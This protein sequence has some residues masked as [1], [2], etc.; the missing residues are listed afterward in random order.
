MMN[1][2]GCGGG[3]PTAAAAANATQRQKTLQQRVDNDIGNIVE[4][5]S[6]IVN[7]SRVTYLLLN[8]YLYT[9]T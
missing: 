3:G 1:K 4:H 5:F 2:G 6:F 7:V 9:C 8:P